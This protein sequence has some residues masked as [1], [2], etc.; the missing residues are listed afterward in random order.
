[1]ARLI[2]QWRHVAPEL[3]ISAVEVIARIHR[4]STIFV[5]IDSHLEPTGLNR[6]EFDLLGTLR[7]LQRDVTPGDLARETAV[8]GAA[9]TKRLKVLHARGLVDR[10]VDERDR[11]VIWAR[12]T[13]AGLALHTEHFSRQL[14]IDRELLS[15]LDDDDHVALVRL[16]SELTTRLEENVA[17]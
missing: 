17:Y 7:R 13:D 12:I 15:G 8:S 2:Q 1:M 3:D 5:G 16:L 6:G 9:V 10:I 11:R 14:E 4:L